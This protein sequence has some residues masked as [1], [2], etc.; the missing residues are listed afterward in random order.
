MQSQQNK[1]NRRRNLCR[2]RELLALNM[3]LRCGEIASL[4]IILYK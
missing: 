1:S 4:S 2:W 3:S